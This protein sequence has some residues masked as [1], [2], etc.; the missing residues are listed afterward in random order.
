MKVGL[1]I[2][3]QQYLDKDMVE[4]LNDQIAMVHLARDKG[5]DSVFSGQH[6]LNEGNNKAFQLVPFLARLMDSPL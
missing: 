1:F 2:T 4:A 3:C 5:W 6:F